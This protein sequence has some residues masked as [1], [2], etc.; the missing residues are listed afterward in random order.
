MNKTIS[1]IRISI[2]FALGGIAMAFIF[3]NEMN[4][5]LSFWALHF[6]ADKAIGIGIG[7]YVGHLYKR[8]SKFDPWLKAY[9][10][11]CAEIMDKSN[12]SQL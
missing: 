7:C 2:L 6:I 4:T 3:G 1:I 10:K 12:P 8:W 11:M 5:P 9:D